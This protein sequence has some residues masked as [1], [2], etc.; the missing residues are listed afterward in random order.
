[1]SKVPEEKI[2]LEDLIQDTWLWLMTYDEGKLLNAYEK[3][4]LN[5]LITSV[6]VKNIFSKKSP[7]FQR[8]HKDS[9][10]CR[11]ITDKELNL[12]DGTGL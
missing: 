12:P 10:R 4:H 7:Y 5:A 6:L 11:E 9:S 2:Y 3:K 1:M 8:Y